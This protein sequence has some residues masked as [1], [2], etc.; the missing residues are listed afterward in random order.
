[1]NTT[2][3]SEETFGLILSCQTERDPNKW[4]RPAL[5]E[6]DE[7]DQTILTHLSEGLTAKE[8]ADKVFLSLPSLKKRIRNLMQT[9]GTR[10]STELVCKLK[11]IAA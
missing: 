8:I 2:T 4:R 9:T 10:N 5:S 3:S 6:I 11:D 7:I 1:M